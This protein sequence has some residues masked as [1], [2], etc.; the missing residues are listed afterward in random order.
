MAAQA[1][2]W[3]MLQR[4][5]KGGQRAGGACRV[6][7]PSFTFVAPVP[8]PAMLGFDLA[9]T[10]GGGT[11]GR[12]EQNVRGSTQGQAAERGSAG[13]SGKKRGSRWLHAGC[14]GP[15]WPHA[16]PRPVTEPCREPAA[17]IGI[18]QLRRG[19]HSA[20]VMQH[21]AGPLPG[22]GS[23]PG[24]RVEAPPVAGYWDWHSRSI[25]RHHTAR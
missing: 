23:A 17:L 11:P 7:Q 25:P 18:P 14:V 13:T 10:C 1:G 19:P 4:G 16:K 20:S 12:E 24:R 6:R 21:P 15:R 2:R 8:S 9:A 3:R 22:S 5:P